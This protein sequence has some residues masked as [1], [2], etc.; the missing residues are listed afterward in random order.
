MYYLR[1]TQLRITTKTGN[2]SFG[3]INMAD[4]TGLLALVPLALG[5]ITV[6]TII[7]VAIFMAKK[8]RETVS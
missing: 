6:T 5:I 2:F 1:G 4:I 3:R 7:A 8:I